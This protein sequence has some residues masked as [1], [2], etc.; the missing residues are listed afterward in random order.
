[1]DEVG[2]VLV[3]AYVTLHEF[4][5]FTLWN[6]LLYAVYYYIYDSSQYGM[7]GYYKA[8]SAR[9]C[10]LWYL[11]DDKVFW[12]NALVILNSIL[13]AFPFWLNFQTAFPLV[14]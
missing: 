2:F 13:D 12:L 1:M 4:I 10:T 11:T 8:C 9:M 7:D 6:F 14:Y 5:L 3:F